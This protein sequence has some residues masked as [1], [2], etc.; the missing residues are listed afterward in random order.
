MIGL[1]I[2]IRIWILVPYSGLEVI[3]FFL[4]GGVSNLEG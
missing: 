1:E 3:V 4:N 2:R